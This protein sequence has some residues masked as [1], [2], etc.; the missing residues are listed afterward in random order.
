VDGRVVWPSCFFMPTHPDIPMSTSEPIKG[1]VQHSYPEARMDRNL[2]AG[3]VGEAYFRLWW[4]ENVHPVAPELALIQFGY[5][6]EGI[7][8]GPQKVEMLKTLKR[9]P[10]FAVVRRSDLGGEAMPIVGISLNGQA[11][12]YTMKQATSPVACFTCPRQKPCFEAATGSGGEF[13]GNLWFNEYNVKNDYRL[14]TEEFGVGV[15]MV[16]I[17]AP[18][19]SRLVR[20]VKANYARECRNAILGAWDDESDIAGFTNFLR[21]EAGT[22]RRRRR[23]REIHWI[24]HE[25]LATGTAPS[26]LTGGNA[27]HG[28]PRPVRCVDVDVAHTEEELISVLR[29]LGDRGKDQ[30]K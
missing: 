28:R 30:P 24:M 26:H 8:V 13:R 21:H 1:S 12:P 27:S 25:E 4:D 2:T 14:F 23:R 16:T 17:L 11:R 15:I 9:S 3:N 20:D 29:S 7:Q 5:N 10:D 18:F 22:P 6:P 19:V